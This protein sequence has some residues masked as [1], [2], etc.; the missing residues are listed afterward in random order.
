MARQRPADRRPIHINR[1]VEE[2][3]DLVTHQLSTTDILVTCD[4]APDLPPVA[5]D[6]DQLSHVLLNLFI[7]AHQAMLDSPRSEEHTSDLQSL[8]RI[9]YAVFCLKLKYSTTIHKTQS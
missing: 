4:L 7:N 3:L 9:Q 8:M 1:L 2:V 6:A 5:G